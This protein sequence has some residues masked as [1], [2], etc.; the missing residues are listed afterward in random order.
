[1]ES[2]VLHGPGF[3][4]RIIVRVSK[5]MRWINHQAVRIGVPGFPW[6]E[7]SFVDHRN[8]QLRRHIA[9]LIL[10]LFP[11]QIPRIVIN[12]RGCGGAFHEAG[13]P[14]LNRN[15]LPLKLGGVHGNSR[16]GVVCELKEIILPPSFFARN[17]L[18]RPFPPIQVGVIHGNT[19]IV[20]GTVCKVDWIVLVGRHALPFVPIYG[21]HPARSI[22][23]CVAQK[24]TVK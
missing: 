14:F 11:I 13:N 3:T 1:M 16:N 18:K 17:V 20:Y 19:P 7:C 24:S 6:D 23:Y 5:I 15:K 22:F 9:Y 12:L 8:M 21:L 10:L 2:K 4:A